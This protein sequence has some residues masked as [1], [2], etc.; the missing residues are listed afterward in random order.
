MVIIQL[1]FEKHTIWY[2]IEWW[3]FIYYFMEEFVRVFWSQYQFHWKK[4]HYIEIK[5]KT[6][7]SN[8]IAD[9]YKSWDP[10]MFFSSVSVISD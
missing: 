5:R 9:S 3:I 8:V 7:R 4:L 1:Y 2:E 10:I 6:V